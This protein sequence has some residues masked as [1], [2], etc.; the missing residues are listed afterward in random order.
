MN[1]LDYCKVKYYL[2]D[3]YK[4]ILTQMQDKLNKDITDISHEMLCIFDDA[5]KKEPSCYWNM[6]V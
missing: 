4:I 3:N 1:C 6:T 5:I 2:Q